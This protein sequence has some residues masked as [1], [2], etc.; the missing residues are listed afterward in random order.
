MHTVEISVIKKLINTDVGLSTALWPTGSDAILSL[1][2]L[3]VDGELRFIFSLGVNEEA[4]FR[5]EVMISLTP[6]PHLCLQ[7]HTCTCL[8]LLFT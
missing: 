4:I 2:A 3:D 6:P 1:A 5:H 8:F 7:S